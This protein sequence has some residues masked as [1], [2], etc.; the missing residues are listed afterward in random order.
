[1]TRTQKAILAL[2]IVLVVIVFLWL[3]SYEENREVRRDAELVG[4]A[5]KADAK[6]ADSRQATTEII[7]SDRQEIDNA[8][9]PLPD[10]PLTDRQRARACAT[11]MRQNPGSDRPAGC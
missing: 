1:M 10:A 11:W 9:A 6:A 5:R 2:A 7:A 4:N 3:R 8:L